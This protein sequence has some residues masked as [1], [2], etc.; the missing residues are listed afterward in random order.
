M[1]SPN[2]WKLASALLVS[3]TCAC[4]QTPN[5]LTVADAPKV[6]VARKATVDHKLKLEVKDGYHVNS[7]KPND[8]YLIPLK[9]TWGEG[10]LEAASLSFPAP[11][12]EEYSFSE[13]PLS[14]FD[15]AFEITTK[16]RPKADAAPGMGFMAG[17]LRYQACND[18]MC[19]PPKTIDIKVPVLIQ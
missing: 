18:K 12:I 14:V 19:L 2:S 10:P 3:L 5:A 1:T 13:K 16:F 17:K 4:A 15:G 9:L 11:K 8:E 6:T 7:H